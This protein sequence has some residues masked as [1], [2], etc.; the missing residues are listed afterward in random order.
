MKTFEFSYKRCARTHGGIF[1]G[2]QYHFPVGMYSDDFIW[3]F[4]RVSVSFGLIFWQLRV[5]C[6]YNKV[7][8]GSEDDKRQ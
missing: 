3:E 5:A 6:N 7:Y 8:I 4:N 2:I 1:L